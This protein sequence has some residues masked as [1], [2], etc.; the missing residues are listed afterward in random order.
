MHHLLLYGHMNEVAVNSHN[1]EQQAM[2]S[3][4]GTNR[5]IYTFTGLGAIFAIL[6]FLVFILLN[7]AISHSVESMQGINNQ[8]TELRGTMD[9]ITVSIR[10]MGSNVQYLHKMSHSVNNLSK[11]TENINGYM[12]ALEKR[13]LKLGTNTRAISA[14]AANINNNFTQINQSMGNISYSVDQAV[15]PIQQFMPMP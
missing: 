8:V 6:I 1:H 11:S 4:R 13:T 2:K 3:I 5:V 15:K 7:K 9:E 12:L 14:Y 10:N